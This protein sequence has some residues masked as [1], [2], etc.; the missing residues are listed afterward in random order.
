MSV[1]MATK[2]ASKAFSIDHATAAKM[3]GVSHATLYNWAKSKRIDSRRRIGPGLKRGRF[4]YCLE[5]VEQVARDYREG[6][7]VGG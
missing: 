6:V 5:D 2:K 1:A 4:F 3:I 7:P